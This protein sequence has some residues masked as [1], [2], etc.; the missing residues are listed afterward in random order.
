[1]LFFLGFAA[2]ATSQSMLQLQLR[3][4]GLHLLTLWR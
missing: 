1:M 4:I 2:A 3:H